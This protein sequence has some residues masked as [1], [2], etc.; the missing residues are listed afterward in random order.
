MS[1]TDVEHAVADHF[2]DEA[3]GAPAGAH[4][5]GRVRARTVHARHRPGRR[6]ALIPLVTAGAVTLV[7]VGAVG[8]AQLAGHGSSRPDRTLVV[9]APP[10]PACLLDHMHVTAVAGPGGKGVSGIVV[11]RNDGDEC[12]LNGYPIVTAPDGAPSALPTRTLAGLFGGYTGSPVPPTVDLPPGDVASALIET[13]PTVPIEGPGCP[14]VNHVAVSL[15]ASDQ[16]VVVAMLVGLCTGQVHPLVP[17]DTGT[18]E[19]PM[20]AGTD[21]FPYRLFTQ[22]GIQYLHLYGRDWAAT[23]PQPDPARLP[24]A[25]GTTVNTGYVAGTMTV[26]DNDTLGYTVTDPLS[27][28][29][30]QT[31]VFH[32]TDQQIPLC[33]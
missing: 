27:G 4:V 10:A 33:S 1:R 20:S 7:I 11:F 12:V 6:A 21:G 28:I 23:D 16:P 8:A 22:C 19:A 25:E 5:V 29:D 32:P 14:D 3:A 9:A 30:G 13:D 18:A 15:A 17:G 26:V 31:F 2:R 24:D